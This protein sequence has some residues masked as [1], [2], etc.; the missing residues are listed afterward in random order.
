MG[1]KNHMNLRHLV[2]IQTDMK[3][4]VN[5]KEKAINDPEN[6]GIYERKM[7]NLYKDLTL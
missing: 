4:V 7:W 2:N 5:L 3:K 6:S 1:D